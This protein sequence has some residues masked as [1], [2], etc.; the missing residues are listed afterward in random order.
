[1]SGKSSGLLLRSGICDTLADRNGNCLA[2]AA[3]A[4]DRAVGAV[5]EAFLKA[6]RSW[7]TG[8]DRVGGFLDAV[9]DCMARGLW[10]GAGT[11]VDRMS[12]WMVREV[13]GVVWPRMRWRVEGVFR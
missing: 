10:R 9:N 2:V 7:R 4:T 13:C 8:V 5:K 12:C 3:N 6:E 11:G 1:M